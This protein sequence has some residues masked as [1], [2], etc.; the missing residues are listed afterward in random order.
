[1]TSEPLPG[2]SWPFR[3]FSLNWS[4]AVSSWFSYFSPLGIISALLPST[5]A[6]AHTVLSLELP[7]QPSIS[8]DQSLVIYQLEC[9]FLK[10]LSSAVPSLGQVPFLSIFMEAYLFWLEL[11]IHR[12]S[13]SLDCKVYESRNHIYF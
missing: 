13:S 8:A 10:E 6:L 5:Q 9:H 11:C 4:Y 1:M 12:L 3:S 7:H 2:L